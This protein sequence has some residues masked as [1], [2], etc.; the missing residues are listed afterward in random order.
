M[1]PKKLILASLMAVMLLPISIGAY[2]RLEISPKEI[3]FKE[4]QFGEQASARLTVRNTGDQPLLIQRV[5]TSCGCTKAD[6]TRIKIHPSDSTE[7]TV[8]FDA[9]GLKAGKKVKTVFLESNDQ[10]NPVTRVKVFATVTR[11]VMIEP[12]RMVTKLDDS[13]E[14][15]EFSLTVR[16]RSSSPVSVALSDIQGSLKKAALIPREVTVSPGSESRVTVRLDLSGTENPKYFSGRLI[17]ETD[18][19]GEKWIGV[20]YFIKVDRSK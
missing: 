2:P 7:M 12:E 8:L 18:H 1:P 11:E 6:L 15:I 14:Q 20:P 5:R 17:L 9:S 16:N 4:V 19:P 3:N 10:E 13:K